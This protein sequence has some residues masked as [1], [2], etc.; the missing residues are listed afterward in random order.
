M[1]P[2]GH[3]FIVRQFRRKENMDGKGEVSSAFYGLRMA[4]LRSII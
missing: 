1:S 2:T 3:F 4:K